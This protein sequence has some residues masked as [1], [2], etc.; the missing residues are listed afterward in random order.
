LCRVQLS[1]T[2]SPKITTIVSQEAKILIQTPAK[3]D[4]PF[5]ISGGGS[6]LLEW[7]R[8][9]V[10]VQAKDLTLHYRDLFLSGGLLHCRSE[11]VHR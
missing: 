8:T 4:D 5:F 1:H 6:R 2:T 9:G 7:L 11:L 10:R 3:I